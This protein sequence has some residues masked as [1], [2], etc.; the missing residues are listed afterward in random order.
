MPEAE[1]FKEGSRGDWLRS[2]L[3]EKVIFYAIKI[4]II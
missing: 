2:T 4:A 1:G 3:K